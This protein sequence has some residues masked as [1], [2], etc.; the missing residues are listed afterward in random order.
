MK[1]NRDTKTKT[2]IFQNENVGF[3]NM[4]KVDFHSA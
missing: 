2:N 4:M 1:M 3:L